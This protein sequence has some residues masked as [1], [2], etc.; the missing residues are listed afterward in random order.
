MNPASVHLVSARVV[1][2]N[3]RQI[4]LTLLLLM[5]WFLPGA[6]LAWPLAMLPANAQSV[7]A[8]N[9]L[10]DATGKAKAI[11]EATGTKPE[12]VKV[13]PGD[14]C[15]IVSAADVKR[16]FPQSLGPTRS[17]RLETYGITE[18]TWKGPKGEVLLGVQESYADSDTTAADEAAGMGTGFLDPLKPAMRKN[19]R[20]ERFAGIA[21][22]NA[23]FVERADPARGLLSD[24]AFLSL[25]KGRQVVT[26]MS[27]NLARIDRAQALRQLEGLGRAASSRLK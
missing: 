12:A 6:L 10:K 3:H 25:T 1:P 21:I 15:T 7:A 14:P 24:G 18:C 17:R 26:L 13:P 9:A 2:R 27:A 19:L 20:I 4:F 8:G 16:V 11:Q 5:Q 23:G 22:D